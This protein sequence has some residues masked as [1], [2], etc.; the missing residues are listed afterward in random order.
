[1]LFCHAYDK[2]NV[3]TLLFVIFR[4]IPRLT[5]LTVFEVTGFMCQFSSLLFS[6]LTDWLVGEII[7][8]D[9]WAEI[10]FQSLS[11]GGPLD[12]SGMAGMLTLWGCPSGISSA[13]HGVAHPPSCPEGWFWRGCRGVWHSRTMQV[14]VSWQL[15]EELPSEVLYFRPAENTGNM[16]V[17]PPPPAYRINSRVQLCNYNEGWKVPTKNIISFWSFEFRCDRYHSAY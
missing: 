5:S 3:L 15:P 14:S 7:M 9:D 8:T 16:I 12:S 2:R 17:P 1:M 4:L 6:P 10:L 13:D 11:A